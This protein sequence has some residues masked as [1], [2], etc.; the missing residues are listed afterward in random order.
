MTDSFRYCEAHTTAYI[1]TGITRWYVL[2]YEGR[3]HFG[4]NNIKKKKKVVAKLPG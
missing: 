1:Q 2:Y 4:I 3:Q